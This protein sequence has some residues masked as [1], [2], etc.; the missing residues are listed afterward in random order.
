MTFLYVYKELKPRGMD[1]KEKHKKK[2]YLVK[3]SF[4]LVLTL[5]AVKVRS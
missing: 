1:L 5:T 2:T 4:Y 3:L